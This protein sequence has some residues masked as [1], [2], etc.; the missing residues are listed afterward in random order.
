MS[1]AYGSQRFDV[2]E[3]CRQQSREMA[4]L[5]ISANQSRYHKI[6]K[7]NNKMNRR[8]LYLC[9]MVAPLWFVFMAI[10]GGAIRPG[11]SHITDTVSELFAPGSTNKSFLDILHTIFAALLIL[12]GIGLLVFFQRT[13]Q[14]KRMGQASACLFI[15]M[16]FV[17]V[18]TA[19]VFPQDPWGTPATFAGEMHKLLSGVI[20]ILSMFSMLLIGIWLVRTKT[21]P[22]FGVYTFI[23]IGMV[24]I[25]AVLFAASTGGPLMG[26]SERIAALVGFQWTFALAYWMYSR[27]SNAG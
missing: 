8:F 14:L 4:E 5:L 10:L 22:G 27:E 1:R 15:L 26:L 13:E 24:V 21:S 2:T 20:G 23:T 17:S 25:T 6:E 12:F 7:R 3:I 19:T 18:M 16:G 9:G 11:Y